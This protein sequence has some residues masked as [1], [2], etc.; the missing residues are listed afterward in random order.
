MQPNAATI[1]LVI[2]L[3]NAIGEPGAFDCHAK[4][5]QPQRHQPL[6]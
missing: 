6:G 2:Q 4:V 3:V 1:E 5:A